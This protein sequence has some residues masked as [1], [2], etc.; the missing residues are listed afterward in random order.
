MFVKIRLK[1][2]Y[3]KMYLDSIIIVMLISS[4]T[5]STRLPLEVFQHHPTEH[6]HHH[7]LNHNSGN[8]HRKK[9]ADF[10]TLK[11]L[12]QIGVSYINK[13]TVQYISKK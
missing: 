7:R 13:T 5:S 1:S 11:I 4:C 2:L 12:Y 3:N 9:I 6:H 8:F 10:T